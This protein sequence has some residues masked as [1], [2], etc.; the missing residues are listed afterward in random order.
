MKKLIICCILITSCLT[1]WS[2]SL[3]ENPVSS[4][5]P[6]AVNNPTGNS[7]LDML[8]GD[9]QKGFTTDEPFLSFTPDGS[10]SIMEMS[11]AGY[12]IKTGRWTLA[13]DGGTLLLHSA[14]GKFEA[15]TIKY[16]ELDEMVLSP[17]DGNGDDWFLNKL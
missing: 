6:V 3:H 8:P 1:A 15:Y 2:A 13:E 11:E 5:V 7:T 10:Y 9:W 4:E 12:H 14:E 16:L 17:A